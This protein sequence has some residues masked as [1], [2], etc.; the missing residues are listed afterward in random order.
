MHLTQSALFIPNANEDV[1]LVQRE[2]ILFF[3]LHDA[4]VLIFIK[5]YTVFLLSLDFLI[6]H[7]VKNPCNAGDH[8]SIPWLRRSAGEGLVYTPVFWPG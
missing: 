5:Q 3:K 6:T 4:I 7:L 1:S 8:S 2:I